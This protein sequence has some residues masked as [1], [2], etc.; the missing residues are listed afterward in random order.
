MAVPRCYVDHISY[1]LCLIMMNKCD[2]L[3]KGRC[4]DVGFVCTWLGHTIEV[5]IIIFF[6]TTE[7][8]NTFCNDEDA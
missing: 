5:F 4:P 7:T 3:D 8:G 6:W 1:V 2:V